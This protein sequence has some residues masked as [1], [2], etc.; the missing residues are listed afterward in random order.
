MVGTVSALRND[1]GLYVRSMGVLPSARGQGV[2]AALLTTV[3][4]YAAER[5]IRVLTLSTTPFLASAIRL[6]ER[7]GY[8]R[9]GTDNLEGTPLFTMKK[10]L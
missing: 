1:D 4:N 9:I 8:A 3:E 7:F 6:Y 10:T 2:A 5:A